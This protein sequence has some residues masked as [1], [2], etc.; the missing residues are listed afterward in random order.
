MLSWLSAKAAA[1][2]EAADSAG[3][4]GLGAGYGG[5]EAGGADSN[6]CETLKISGAGSFGHDARSELCPCCLR[7]GTIAS[8]WED[9]VEGCDDSRRRFM[10]GFTLLSLGYPL[11]CPFY[12]LPN[13][14][15]NSSASSAEI[16]GV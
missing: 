5:N 1:A 15:R 16:P 3:V 4:A 2:A 12:E 6:N 8:E 9:V 7:C 11:A 13:L 10:F 14:L